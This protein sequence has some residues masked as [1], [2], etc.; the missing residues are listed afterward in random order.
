MGFLS[1][2]A[3]EIEEA[4]R[5]D[6]PILRREAIG[7]VGRAEVEDLV[8][9]LLE[10]AADT[11]EDGD[12]RIAAIEALEELQ[13]AE[14]VDVLDDLLDD[15]DAEVARAAQEALTEISAWA[16]IEEGGFDLDD[17]QALEWDDELEN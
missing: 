6:D 10:V 12:D 11:G 7:A 2:F 8:P 17:I 1:G 9:D 15:D 16:E 13:L 3:D 4:F 14:A 5:S